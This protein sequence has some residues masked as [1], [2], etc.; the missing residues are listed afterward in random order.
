M[1]FTNIQ[2]LRVA[3]AVGVVLYHLGCHAP[4]LVGLDPV[5]LRYP[6]IAGFP[7]PLFFAVSGFVLTHAIRSAPPGRFLLA[8]FLRLY[9]GYWLALLGVIV[10]MR[11]QLYTE[12][13]RWLIHFVNAHTLSL[14]PAGVGRAVYFLGV[15][16][17]L[18]YEVFLSVALAG[19]SLFGARR[20]VPILTAV[21][22]AVIGVKMTMWPGYLYDQFPHWS[23]IAL[24]G[25]NV[26]FLLGVL[27]YQVRGCGRRWG[28]VV[29]PVVVGLLYV[30]CTRPMLAEQQW[31]CWGAAAA[32]VVWLAVRLR[33]V[34]ERNPLARLGDCTY[35]LFLFHVPLMLGVFYAAARVGWVGRWE[36]V[37]LAGAVAVVGGMLFGRLEC[38]L[39]ARLRPLAKVKFGDV[40]SRM[41]RAWFA[42]TRRGARNVARSSSSRG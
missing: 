8:R 16:W 7:V 35:G 29:A 18:V 34:S 33:Q 32:G 9:P 10:L 36:V 27:A 30:V 31:C 1:R 17:S 2:L 15:E 28:F 11:L 12:H 40:K 37:W 42:A 3:A 26:P 6:L 20:G 38:A 14:W 21:W 39:H 25:Y 4:L 5:W 13:H 41:A 19:L 23:T 24:S 22:L